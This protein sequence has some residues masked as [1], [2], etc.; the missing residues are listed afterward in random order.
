VDALKVCWKNRAD[1]S[2][3]CKAWRRQYTTHKEEIAAAVARLPHM[4]PFVRECGVSE[5]HL[6]ALANAPWFRERVFDKYL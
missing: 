3:Y 6:T 1:Y 5:K 2:E 4:L